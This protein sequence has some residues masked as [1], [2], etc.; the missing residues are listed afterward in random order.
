MTAPMIA[1]LAAW[2]SICG[3]WAL[4][5][6]AQ[7]RVRREGLLLRPLVGDLERA[8]ALPSVSVVIPARN[9]AAALENCLHSVLSQGYPNLSVVVI[10][11]RSEDGT[12]A[13]ADRIARRDA[14]VQPLRVASLPDGWMGKSHALWSATRQVTA[15]WLLFLD[16]DC[17]L[18]PHAIQ[19]AIC[20]ARRRNV[21]FLSLWPGQAP[22]NF[23]EHALIPLCAAIIALWFGAR[24]R[25]AFAN[26][27][28]L[29]VRRSA[30]ERIGGHRAVRSALIEDIP[31]AECAARAGVAPWVASGRDLVRVRMY[32][33]LNEIIRG[34][35]R[36]YVGALRS[37]VKIVL[38][39]LWLLFG[40]L[41]PYVAIV[42]LAAAL[43]WPSPFHVQRPPHAL[44]AV[45]FTGPT[46]F[47]QSA[48]FLLASS[49]CLLHLAL[50]LTASWRFW[51]MGGCKRAYLLLY[52]LS[53][54]V[55]IRILAQAWWW[56]VVRRQVP[57]RD[58]VY[59]TD[60]RGTIVTRR[61]GDRTSMD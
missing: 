18:G 44:T 15:D 28:F 47:T 45:T 19:T 12:A 50:M 24:K 48:T 26:G 32:S 31:L 49:L 1:L 29:L 22:G 52:P 53:T 54:I 2:G 46:W 61:T 38:S 8:D 55:V 6:V 16:V 60:P 43:V 40:S 17:T 41:L 35:A 13:I 58:R 30:Y 39:I 59:T 37:G 11:D 57:W 7:L 10:D 36:I 56:L 9:E 23:W 51:G 3:V 21:E 5:L 14:R 20:E 33:G 4:L 42:F 25:P 34:W 27:Q